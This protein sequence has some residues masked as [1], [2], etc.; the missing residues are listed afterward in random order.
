M[1]AFE[2]VFGDPAPFL[3]KV[4]QEVGS[5]VLVDR[6]ELDHI[7][8][9][10]ETNER[11]EDC[12]KALDEMG[13]LLT[14]TK[15]SNRLIATYKLYEPIQFQHR[16]IDLLELPSPK[17][18][19]FYPEGFEHVEFVVGS[20]LE[21]FMEKY[22]HLPFDKKGFTKKVNRDLRLSFDGFSVKFHEH[23]L[24]YVIRYLDG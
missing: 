21:V 9:R 3:E 20:N 16:S 17:K 24:E 4:F 8:Y 13:A 19:S 1:N 7:C 14:E 22:K 18:G 23:S 12:K 10:V 5:L 11:Y 2:T 15:I 6:F